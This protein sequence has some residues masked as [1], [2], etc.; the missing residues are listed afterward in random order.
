MPCEEFATLAST[1]P[2]R[3]FQDCESDGHYRCRECVRLLR[4]PARDGEEPWRS[5]Q[6]VARDILVTNGADEKSP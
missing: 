3:R 4:R 5:G 2:L 1:H 6:Q